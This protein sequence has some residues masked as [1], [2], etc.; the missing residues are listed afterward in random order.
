MG[1]IYVDAYYA[2]GK[3]VSN[4]GDIN[5]YSCGEFDEEY[6]TQIEN[7][8]GN[9]KVKNEVNK[10]LLTTTGRSK[11]VVAFGKVKEGY[12]FQ[13]KI[14]TSTQGNCVIYISWEMI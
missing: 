8:D 9:V 3:F 7:V 5:V 14:N 6:F 13:H 2:S 11:V 1:N 4:K 12:V 10:L